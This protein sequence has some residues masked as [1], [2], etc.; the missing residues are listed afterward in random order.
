MNGD[1]NRNLEL[2]DRLNR[3]LSAAEM[4]ENARARLDEA[5]E[6]LKNTDF[7]TSEIFTRL[8]NLEGL[9]VGKPKSF[10]EEREFSI[11]LQNVKDNTSTIISLELLFNQQS[12]KQKTE[13]S[14]LT[15]LIAGLTQKI[16]AIGNEGTV[17]PSG[18]DSELDALQLSVND[19][20]V[21][22]AENLKITGELDT[23]VRKSVD[24]LQ[25]NISSL[26]RKTSEI[27]SRLNTTPDQEV[28]HFSV[29]LQQLRNELNQFG[30]KLNSLSGRTIEMTEFQKLTK[31]MEV[32]REK[33]S[34]LS[35][36]PVT[37]YDLADRLNML[38]RINAQLERRISNIYMQWFISYIGLVL[39]ICSLAFMAMR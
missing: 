11:L 29:E 33:L 21:S 34:Q 39:F 8:S 4:L 37:V 10:S 6:Q 9:I 25:T 14:N 7:N 35:S 20:T 38:E 2:T 1:I 24:Q 13:L 22:I 28:D 19:A 16:D 18:F 5:S 17:E 23:L 15:D 30:T 26:E 3:L 36:I 32:F 12:E 27:E 31:E